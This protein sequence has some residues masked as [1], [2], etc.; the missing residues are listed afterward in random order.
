MEGRLSWKI[1]TQPMAEYKFDVF[2]ALE[3]VDKRDGSWFAKQ[4]EDA[5][6]AFAAPV[7]MRFA[8]S[9]AGDGMNHEF[10]L[11]IVN[12]MVNVNAEV[13][14][15]AHPELFFRLTAL[16]GLGKVKHHPWIPMT[17]RKNAKSS[18]AYD[19]IAR[20]NPTANVNE[21]NLLMHLHTKESFKEFAEG[22]GYPPEDI[23]AAIKSYSEY[24]KK[25]ADN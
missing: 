23:K 6:K 4:P 12:E 18:K 25:N 24:L 16:A 21:V 3:A 9:L 19:M 17:G 22:S 15:T 1:G 8:S 7:F 20:F 10:M 14:M 13:F 5:R 11:T 2:K